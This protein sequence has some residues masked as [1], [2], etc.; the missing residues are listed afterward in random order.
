M[1]A[2]QLLERG[3]LP[4]ALIRLGIRQRLANRIRHESATP[5]TERRQKLVKFAEELKTLPI[6]I[7]TKAAND[8]HY[9]LPAKFF[10]L[11]LGK[12]LKYSSAYYPEGCDSLDE[13]E[14][15]MLRLTCERAGLQDGDRILELGCGWGSLTLWMG[16]H[17]PKSRITGVSNSNSQREFIL[18][19]AK[20]RGL[21]NIE[22]VTADMNDFE[23]EANQFDRAVSVEMFEH[24]KNY[25]LLMSRIAQWLKPGG[26]LFVHIFTH[27]EFA[28]H[29]ESN[30]PNDFIGNH[31]FQ[32]R[33]HAVR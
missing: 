29:Y 12:N 31:F 15:E 11:C 8:Q 33:H 18:G 10:Q 14:D 27:R 7:E 6:A 30:D 16:K 32:R 2:L 9:E 19:Q 13:A 17:F 5:V 4:D 21:D 3:V 20:E 24:M 22:I 28:H 26:T 1:N 25:Q 23:T